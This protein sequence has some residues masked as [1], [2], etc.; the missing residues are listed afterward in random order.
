MSV[1]SKVA[2]QLKVDSLHKTSAGRISVE[3]K[4]IGPQPSVYTPS[5]PRSAIGLAQEGGSGEE[6]DVQG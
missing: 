6:S 1:Q 4:E 2:E 5:K 3:V